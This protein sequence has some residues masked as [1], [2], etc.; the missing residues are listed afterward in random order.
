MV[1]WG[2]AV[3]VVQAAA[4][5]LLTD[6]SGLGG[7]STASSCPGAHTFCDDFDSYDL[8]VLWTSVTQT[9]GPMGLDVT[10]DVSPP[11]S[12]LVTATAGQAKAVSA[13]RKDFTMSSKIDVAFDSYIEP[14]TNDTP[15]E[16]DPVRVDYQIPPTGFISY[17]VHVS[18]YDTG[19]VIEEGG[20]DSSGSESYTETALPANGTFPG[21]WQHY[22]FEVDASNATASLSVAGATVATHTLTRPPSWSV[23]LVIGGAYEEGVTGWR[24]HVDNVV[25]DLL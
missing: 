9:G 2:G 11:R 8:G 1:R 12:L 15:Y 25:V 19:P 23:Q 17:S 16:V 24:I 14:G 4:C 18:L 22:V 3:L 10:T 21:P 7:S 13:L 6:L 20:T 5:S